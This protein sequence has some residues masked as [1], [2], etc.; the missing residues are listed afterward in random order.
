MVFNESLVYMFCLLVRGTGVGLGLLSCVLFVHVLLLN[1]SDVYQCTQQF[2]SRPSLFED[3]Q[4]GTT[5][6][7]CKKIA[8]RGCLNRTGIHL[9]SAQGRLFHWLSCSIL[10]SVCL[11]VVVPS[12]RQGEDGV[13]DGR[14]LLLRQ[15]C[16]QLA[17]AGV[18]IEDSG[19]RS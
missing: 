13:A 12:P 2:H 19:P 17:A 16:R 5:T 3:F 18:S 4:K 7:T 9:Q 11:F 15:R 6:T 1:S 10:P 8:S 14:T